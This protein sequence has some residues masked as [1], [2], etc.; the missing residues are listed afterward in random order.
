MLK[1][2]IINTI[3]T[4]DYDR[5]CTFNGGKPVDSNYITEWK[6]IEPIVV[7]AKLKKR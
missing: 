6:N 1:K 4:Q 2:V 5:I 3:Y 7:E